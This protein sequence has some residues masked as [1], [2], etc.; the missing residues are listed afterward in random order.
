MIN[1][2]VH[3]Q[4]RNHKKNY[5]LIDLIFF[6]RNDNVKLEIERLKKELK[7]SKKTS[8]P[9]KSSEEIIEEETERKS[10]DFH[11]HDFILFKFSCTSS[12]TTSYCRYFCING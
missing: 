11:I 5:N 2:I 9:V 10:V 6:Y 1:R 8:V 12:F 4:N 7:Q 3:H